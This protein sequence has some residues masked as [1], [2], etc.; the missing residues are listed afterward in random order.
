MSKRSPVL[1]QTGVAGTVEVSGAIPTLSPTQRD[2]ALPPM[3]ITLTGGTFG[4]AVRATVTVQLN[5]AA[6]GN[7]ATLIAAT[8]VVPGRR[9]GNTVVFPDVVF[10]QPGPR[11]RR[12]FRITNLRGNAS[13]LGVTR[14]D[15]QPSFTTGGSRSSADGDG[16][17]ADVGP[18]LRHAGRRD[19]A[20]CQ[21]DGSVGAT[22]SGRLSGETAVPGGKRRLRHPE[23]PVHRGTGDAHA[24]SDAT[25]SGVQ[26]PGGMHLRRSRSDLNSDGHVRLEARPGGI[27]AAASLE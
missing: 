24:V 27:P 21:R 19:T 9:R 17:D 2:V 11:L 23:S 1:R 18:P 4:V 8:Q 3:R 7:Q 25:A 5:A 16:V 13:G 12:V 22:G 14:R 26:R 6:T 15:G 10:S 20:P